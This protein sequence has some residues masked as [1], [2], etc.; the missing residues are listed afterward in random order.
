MTMGEIE[1]PNQGVRK[2]TFEKIKRVNQKNIT[3][4]ATLN[5]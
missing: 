3:Y 1:K 2:M 4:Q 5:Y